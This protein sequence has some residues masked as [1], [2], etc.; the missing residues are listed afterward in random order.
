MPKDVDDFEFEAYSLINILRSSP[1][2]FADLFLEPLKN[3]FDVYSNDYQPFEGERYATEEGVE[4]VEI[5]I[6]HLKCTID[7]P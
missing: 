5:G 6:E 1:S 4:S 3:Q 2:K 7:L